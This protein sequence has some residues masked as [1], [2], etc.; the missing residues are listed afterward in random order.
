MCLGGSKA[1]KTG[2]MFPS[3]SS[4]RL[5][6][7]RPDFGKYLLDKIEFTFENFE[8]RLFDPKLLC[9]NSLVHFFFFFNGELNKSNDQD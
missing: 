4:L 8:D 3:Q 2:H 6:Q 9:L 7:S 1:S 5:L